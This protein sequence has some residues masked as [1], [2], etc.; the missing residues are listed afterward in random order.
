ML[1]IVFQRVFLGEN[2]ITIGGNLY[3]YP[4]LRP[5][6]WGSAAANHHQT[7]KSLGPS[8]WQQPSVTEV[9][10]QLDASKM[11]QSAVS[12]P[13]SRILQV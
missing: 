13:Q 5:F 8:L 7:A 9:L 4:F 12:F 3:L 10:E 1:Q 2:C 6:L 11:D